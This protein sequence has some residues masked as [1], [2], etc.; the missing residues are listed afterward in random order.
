MTDNNV[1]A[2]AKFWNKENTM[3]DM[4]DNPDLCDEA[5]GYIADLIA[6]VKSL[7]AE[8][9]ELKKAVCSK[10][11]DFGKPCAECKFNRKEGK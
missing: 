3:L 6:E 11:V 5:K 9:D 1:V 2:E 8:R 10:C 4:M 7:T